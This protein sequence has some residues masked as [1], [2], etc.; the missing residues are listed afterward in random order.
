MAMKQT[1]LFWRLQLHEGQC[2]GKQQ[3]V[4]CRRLLQGWLGCGTGSVT[5]AG[6][7]RAP[8]PWQGPGQP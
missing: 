3:Q 6:G 5:S 8:R 4:S 7:E 1:M 2:P